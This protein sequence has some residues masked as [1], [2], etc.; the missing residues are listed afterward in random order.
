VATPADVPQVIADAAAA[1]GRTPVSWRVPAFGLSA[2]ERYVVRFGDGSS[3]FVKGATDE[4]TAAWLRNE[5]VALTDVGGSLG[6]DVITLIDRR[7]PILVT[8]DLTDAYWPAH[9]GVVEWRPGDMD[10][11]LATL[12]TLRARTP[13][14]H[15]GPVTEW[16]RPQWAT[17][18]R[19]GSLVDAGLC[20][21]RWAARAAPGIIE[22]D[23][24]ATMTA[25]AFVHG[26]VRSDNVCVRD[27]GVLLVDWSS[28]G[29]G[30]PLH[31]LVQL[32]PTLHLEGGPEPWTL[33]RE[34]VDVIARLG[35][36]IA[37][38][39]CN[40]SSAPAWLR[41]VLLKLAAINLAWVAAA[42]DIEPPDGEEAHD[43]PRRSAGT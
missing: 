12:E 18:F 43:G 5:H 1:L 7:H 33:L 9:D 14:A 19:E 20:S 41:R 2:A 26:D 28:S 16:P 24:L 35:G 38:R 11:L 25:T 32:L 21:S 3:V 37:R 8:A 31:D 22:S 34:P 36:P 17:L 29:V 39:G 23:E 27:G 30:H 40:D 15:L 4:Q 10:L 13:P 6:P 42:L